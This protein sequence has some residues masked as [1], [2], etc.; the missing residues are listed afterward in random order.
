MTYLLTTDHRRLIGHTLLL[1]V[2]QI[3]KMSPI[4]LCVHK[5]KF[6]KCYITSKRQSRHKENHSVR[7]LFKTMVGG[8][9]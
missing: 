3:L 1:S 9:E 6:V 2:C 7:R 4:T 8:G 5:T